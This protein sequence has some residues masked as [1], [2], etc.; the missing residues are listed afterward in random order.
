MPFQLDLGSAT[1]GAQPLD[2]A[3]EFGEAVHRDL[4][5]GVGAGDAAQIVLDASRSTYDIRWGS[6]DLGVLNRGAFHPTKG[7]K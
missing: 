6:L 5:G 2:L 1:E 3:R 4:G 7:S